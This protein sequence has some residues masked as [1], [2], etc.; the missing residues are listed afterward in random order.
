MQS[1][2]TTDMSAGTRRPSMIHSHGLPL[3][4]CH[5]TRFTLIVTVR[6]CDVN[7]C[8]VGTRCLPEQSNELTEALTTSGPLERFDRADGTPQPDSLPNHNQRSGCI[9]RPECVNV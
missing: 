9:C 6:D 4:R 3:Q 1:K 2:L 7:A 8:L 5:L